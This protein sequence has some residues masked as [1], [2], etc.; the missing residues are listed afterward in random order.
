M[1]III[2]R[3][4][5]NKTPQ[6]SEMSIKI[7]KA[8]TLLNALYDIKANKDNSLTFKS[9][10]KS[11]VCGSCSMRVNSKE[12]LACSY[13]LQDG[14][15]IE[16]LN[17]HNIKRDLVVERTHSLQTLKSSKAWLKSY[18]KTSI[19]IAQEKLTEVQ[20]DCIL[21]SS[22][23]SS[24]PVMAVNSDFLGPFG[25]TRVYRYLADEREGNIEEGVEAIQINGVWDCTLCGECTTVCPQG[26]DPKMDIMQ[27]RGISTQYGY[28]DPS[29]S[30]MSFGGFDPNI[31]F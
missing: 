14:D 20:S 1:N 11:G 6:N 16:P 3:F 28:S 31:G 23:Y 30:N 27:L 25:L 8:M 12:V 4:D 29:F 26:I 9:G 18:K 5:K 19:S 2:K 17:Y 10:C 7:D 22:C 24:C 13:K 21:C 15:I